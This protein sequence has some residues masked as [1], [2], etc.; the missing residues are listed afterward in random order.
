[1]ARANEMNS[2]NNSSF[3]LNNQEAEYHLLRYILG[4]LSPA[5]KKKIA[6]KLERER[7]HFSRSETL[8]HNPWYDHK[9]A[10]CAAMERLT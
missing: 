3:A 2:Y 6:A 4:E 9:L 7:K 5:V 10:L 8:G 1:M